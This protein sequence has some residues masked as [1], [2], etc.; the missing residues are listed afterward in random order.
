MYV[1]F[2]IC[3][4]VVIINWLRS[5]IFV[6]FFYSFKFDFFETF[7][8]RA[9]WSPCPILTHSHLLMLLLSLFGYMLFFMNLEYLSGILL[10]YGVTILEQY[11]SPPTRY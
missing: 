7:K 2:K 4:R 9:Q 1:R 11:I 8:K 10:Y 5:H 3:I 6:E